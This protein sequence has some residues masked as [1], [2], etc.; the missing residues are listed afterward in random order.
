MPLSFL[1]LTNFLACRQPEQTP[2]SFESAVLDPPFEH[3]NSGWAG[4]ALLDYDNDGW[5]DI[6]FTNGLS[7]PD[8]LYRNLGNGHFRDVASEVGLDSTEQHGGVAAGDLDNAG[9]MDLA[10]TKDCSLGTLK[11]NG[12]A[13]PDGGIVVYWNNDGIFEEQR[14]ELPPLIQ[15]RG[16]CPTSIELYDTNLDGFLDLSVSNGMDLDQVYPWLFRKI[17]T[18]SIDYIILNDENHSFSEHAKFYAQFGSDFEDVDTLAEPPQ[19]MQRVTFTSAYLD[20]DR[21]GLPDRILGHGGGHLSV[22]LQKD[23]AAYPA[24][25]YLF[26]N[27]LV[28]PEGLWMGL[29]LADFDGD[30]D[31]DIY[32]TNQGLSP[33]ILGYDNLPWDGLEEIGTNQYR[34]KDSLTPFHSVYLLN[35][36]A[37]EFQ[38]DWPLD[39]ENLLPGDLFDGMPNEDGSLRFPEWTEPEALRRF[40][41]GWGATAVD[42]DADGWMDVVFNGNNCAAPMNVIGSEERGAGP[43]AVLRNNEGKGFQDMTWEW[44]LANLDE[45]GSYPDG[46]GVAVGDLNNDGFSDVVFANRS[47]NPSQSGP[48]EQFPG[49]PNVYLSKGNPNNWLQIDLVGHTS[50]RDGIGSMIRIDYENENRFYVFEPGGTTNASNERLFTV[51]VGQNKTVSVKVQFPSGKVVTQEDVKVNQRIVIEEK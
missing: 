17:I 31:I 36:K 30:S 44:G 9:D 50:N 28:G 49:I 41:W 3:G 14:I 45:S 22:Y 1:L 39:S 21:N 7:Q 47:Y 34:E 38:A 32:S 19:D 2:P 29:A 8:A 23:T 16:T 15:A 37:Y 12:H 24:G 35:N 48:L 25:F 4:V 11:P 40:G 20:V 27:Y 6:F 51:G 42:I 43:G 13:Y 33:L 18:E 5:L 10:I 46:R 26:D